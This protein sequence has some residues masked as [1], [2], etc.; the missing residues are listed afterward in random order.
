MGCNNILTTAQ[1]R[2][3]ANL[4]KPFDKDQLDSETD[5]ESETERINR[6]GERYKPAPRKRAAGVRDQLR[7]ASLSEGGGKRKLDEVKVG[8]STEVQASAEGKP[9]RSKLTFEAI[10]PVELEKPETKLSIE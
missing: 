8:G 10:V 5:S 4:F 6:Y 9:K 2:E 1:K 7:E 3:A